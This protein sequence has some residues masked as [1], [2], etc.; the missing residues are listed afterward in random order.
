LIS[1]NQNLTID[2]IEKY[3]DKPWNWSWISEQKFVND[4][5]IELMNLCKESHKK[6]L[7]EVMSEYQEVCLHPDNMNVMKQLGVYSDI[8]QNWT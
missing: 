6:Q 7:S 8:S 3:P 2:I 5:E 4:Y 1:R